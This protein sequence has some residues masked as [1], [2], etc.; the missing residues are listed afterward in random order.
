MTEKNKPLLNWLESNT[1][2]GIIFDFDGTLLDINEPLERSIEE[3][4]KENKIEYDMET[5]SKEI[6]AV[7][8]SVQGYPLPKIILQSH[9]I[10]EHITSLSNITF[11]KKLSIATK[12]FSKYLEYEKDA[13]FFPKA[14]LLIKELSKKYDL[15]IVSH[16]QTKNLVQHL[17]EENCIEYFEDIYG[18][19]ELPVLKPDPRALQPVL[20]HYNPFHGNEFLMIGDMPTDIEAGREAGIWTIAIPSGISSKE[21]LQNL[22]PDLLLE[23]LDQLFEIF[24]IKYKELSNSNEKNSLKIKS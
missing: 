9:Q 2:R 6:G 15:Y 23:S 24:G 1:L 19:D 10:F 20:S 12:I 4:L 17:K 16:N 18:A 14:I 13:K 3:V 7:I 21:I 11:L 22:Y 5:T 8:E